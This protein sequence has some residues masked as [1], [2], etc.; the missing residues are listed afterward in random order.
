[1]SPGGTGG[2][3]P[4]SEIA[5]EP[6]VRGAASLVI[7]A[8][9]GMAALLAFHAT[10]KAGLDLPVLALRAW[11]L[12]YLGAFVLAA[13]AVGA[14]ILRALS[15]P[16]PATWFSL[17]AFGLGTA[18]YSFVGLGLALLQLFRAGLLS[19]LVLIPALLSVR[20]SRSLYASLSTFIRSQRGLVGRRPQAVLLLLFSLLALSPP[21]WIDPLA[22]HLVTPKEYLLHGGIPAETANILTFSPSAM[23]VLFGFLM[24]GGS[25][26]LPKLLHFV[27][28]LACLGLLFELGR[29]LFTPATGGLACLLMAA[30]W[31]VF[32]GV[33]WEN[34]DFHTLFFS[35]FALALTL[36]A[37]EGPP[38]A[39]R[40][41]L[42]LLAGLFIGTALA[43]KYTAVFSAVGIGAVA[44]LAAWRRQLRLRDLLILN[45]SAFAMLLPMLVRNVMFTG[46]PLFP[47]LAGR[48]GAYSL[49][50]KEQIEAW[51]AFLGIYTPQLT[52][53]SVVM[54]PLLAYVGAR[55]PSV[56]YDGYWDP[57]YLLTIPLGLLLIRR[58]QHVGQLYVFLLFFMAA[59]LTAPYIR[60]ALP[61]IA[62]TS[63]LTAGCV[64]Q[65]PLLL[66]GGRGTAVVRLFG[67]SCVIA[68]A[69]IQIVSFWGL[70]RSL[71]V[72][73]PSAFL[74]I[75][76]RRTFLRTTQAGEVFEVNEYLRANAK[77]GERLFMILADQPYYLDLPAFADPTRTN[78]A[79]LR[80]QHDPIV[81]LRERDYR[82]VLVDEGRVHWIR[83]QKPVDPSFNPDPNAMRSFEELWGWWKH[84]LEPRLR[85]IARF[86]AHVLFEAPPT[87]SPA[88]QPAFILQ[89][90]KGY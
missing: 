33:Q 28:L 74:G 76:D 78:L 63:L 43:G 11:D 69:L 73:G 19:A 57:F 15:V 82:Y 27:F 88:G 90:R 2:P 87:G 39:V 62:I 51:N 84:D 61:A 64:D 25:D 14:R 16:L 32:H 21:W 7:A 71:I 75:E 24:A 13:H 4:D 36:L 70:G 55:F 48:L 58:R 72:H 10:V 50:S 53:R 44:L 30:Q 52:P 77:P 59:W 18:T 17:A 41:R 35:L 8:T 79:L 5:P 37:N 68:F 1:M 86:G 31:E 60:Y 6:P 85:P 42:M 83:S 22:Y 20:E 67:R 80:A 49:I 47:I 38:P 26:H 12:I 45:V 23:E 65:L 29:R 89:E 56:N 54:L 3:S 9:L 46:D 34:V 40:S 81:W 66:G